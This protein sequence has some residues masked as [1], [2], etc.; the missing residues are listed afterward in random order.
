MAKYGSAAAPVP[1]DV[2][3]LA[4]S[5][6]YVEYDR[7]GRVVKGVEVKAKS[8]YEEDVLI[9]NHTCV[10][11]S[12]WRDGQWGFAC[13]HSTVKNSYCTGK[14]RAPRGVGWVAWAGWCGF[15]VCVWHEGGCASGYEGC[16]RSHQ[17]SQHVSRL[18]F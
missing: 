16:V 1:E 4:A 8:R 17:R 3:A 13:C 5:E 12:W 10:W 18:S 2:K 15:G 6:R 9:N 14:V 11:G 7:T